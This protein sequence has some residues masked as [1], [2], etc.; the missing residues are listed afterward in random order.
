M[1]RL[2]GLVLSFSSVFAFANHIPAEWQGRYA[3][4]CG[5]L[6][7]RDLDS[8]EKTFS[9]DF[10]AIDPKGKTIDAAAFFKEMDETFAGVT[11]VT[12]KMDLKSVEAGSDWAKVAFDFKLTYTYGTHGTWVIHE[13]GVDTWHK[14]GDTWLFAKTVDST[15]TWGKLNSKKH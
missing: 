13:I 14:T 15:L 2:A 9:P 8:F 6:N 3:T 4:V 7:A 5:Y 10:I 11:A 12:T 1:K